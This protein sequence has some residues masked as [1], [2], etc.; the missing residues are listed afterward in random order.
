MSEKNKK[1]TWNEFFFE[2]PLY[3]KL[4]FEDF[5]NSEMDYEI[6]WYSPKNNI[7]TTYNVFEGLN[8][9]SCDGERIEYT[10]NRRYTFELNNFHQIR[11]ECRRKWDETIIYYLYVWKYYIEKVWQSPSLADMQFAELGKK[12]DKVLERDDLK[13]FKKAIWL[14][15]YWVWAGAFVYLRRIFEHL[16]FDTFWEHKTTLWLDDSDFKLK[17]MEEKIEILKSFLPEQL[18]V[19][20]KIYWI[21]SKWVHELSEE[22]CLKYFPALKLSIELILD[23]KIEMDLKESRDKQAQEQIQWII[24]ELS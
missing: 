4:K 20:K 2:I 5:F 7:E 21:L 12:Y 11:L 13:L 18:V 22:D 19:M 17:H 10:N 9:G 8:L 23:Q 1:I 24:K 16:I 3:Q 15:A 14:N 6:D